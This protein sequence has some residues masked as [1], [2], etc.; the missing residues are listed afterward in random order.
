MRYYDPIESQ[1]IS[2]YTPVEMPFREAYLV[3]SVLQRR[4][5]QAL[6]QLGGIKPNIDAIG[7]S[8]A[9]RM[10]MDKFQKSQ[11][12]V[13]DLYNRYQESGQPL[14]TFAG[15]ISNLQR[16]VQQDPRDPLFSRHREEFNKGS[17][18]LEKSVLSTDAQRA[19]RQAWLNEYNKNIGEGNYMINAEQM[20]SPGDFGDVEEGI[21]TQRQSRR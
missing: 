15:E 9:E 17:A 3:G 19:V 12:A 10:Q 1:F 4:E 6:S 13:Q 16:A 8:V 7:G 5:D 21:L 2:Q 11:Q 14:S 20:F 18:E